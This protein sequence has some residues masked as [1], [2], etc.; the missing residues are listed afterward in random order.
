MKKHY[1]ISITFTDQQYET[2]LE[3]A[4]EFANTLSEEAFYYVYDVVD[5]DTKERFTVDLS[6]ED[7]NSVLTNNY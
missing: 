5:E 2:P 1:T 6:E 3:A 7:E 4:K